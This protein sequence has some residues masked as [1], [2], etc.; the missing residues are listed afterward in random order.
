MFFE[1]TRPYLHGEIVGIGLLLQNFFNGES[2]NNEFLLSLAK[3]YG[4]PCS[5]SDIGLSAD[6]NTK[7]IFFEQLSAS[8]AIDS[9]NPIETA[10]LADGLDYL[11]SIK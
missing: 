10:K 2:E 8:S 1:E 6:G 5:V 9:E 11:F 4:M 7:R 3:K